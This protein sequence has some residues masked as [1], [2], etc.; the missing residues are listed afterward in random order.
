MVGR[1]MPQPDFAYMSS[2]PGNGPWGPGSTRRCGPESPQDFFFFFIFF[3]FF[4]I[5]FW[6]HI[7]SPRQSA[8]HVSLT[9]ISGF[10]EL[11]PCLFRWLPS[12]AKPKPERRHKECFSQATA[13][14]RQCYLLFV[15]TL[16]CVSTFWSTCL[17]TYPSHQHRRTT[18]T[19]AHS[20]LPLSHLA[21]L[22]GP[23]LQRHPG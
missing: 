20:R 5:V 14:V 9:N 8:P 17:P 4:M 3:S 18:A 1:E 16:S 19:S 22:R 21:Y 7:F 13:K 12:A 11:K 15:T 6:L 2:V 23:L 10:L